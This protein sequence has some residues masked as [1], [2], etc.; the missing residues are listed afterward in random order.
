MRNKRREYKSGYY[1]PINH[2]KFGVER[3]V[4]R[5]SWERDFLKWADINDKIVKVQY[6]K[7]VIPYKCAT[8]NKIH[9]Y[10]VDVKLTIQ[11]G[12]KLVVYLIEIKPF[13]KTVPPKESKR[14]KKTTILFEQVEWA[15]NTSKWKSAEQYCRD[16]GYRWC[17]M[18]EKGI[19]IDNKFFSISI[20]K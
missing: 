2:H 11:E 17:I 13:N 20:F 12:D 8:D 1:R 7:I 10:H 18:T 4:Y 6:E 15:K 16:R 9:K 19:Y 14:K 3:C 5:S